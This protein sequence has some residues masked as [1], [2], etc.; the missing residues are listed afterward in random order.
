[1]E[2]TCGVPNGLGWSP[3]DRTMY[4]TDSVD[5]TIYAFDF[6]IEQG[7]ISN[8][9]VFVRFDDTLHGKTTE[10]PDGLCVDA[11][12]CVWT[13]MYEGGR[14]LRISPQG[15]IVKQ[16]KVPAWRVS[17]PCFGGRNM[18]ELFLTSIELDSGDEDHKR[19]YGQD[20]NVL[21]I[22]IPGVDGLPKNRF[23][24]AGGL[25]LELFSL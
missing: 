24:Q 18:D 13:A 15:R 7:T 17:C 21:R 4:W 23:G 3:D 5:A 1:M 12:G 25:N 10:V 2:G 19:E 6:S 9:R 14:V 8:R 22:R 20:G 11:E 16:I